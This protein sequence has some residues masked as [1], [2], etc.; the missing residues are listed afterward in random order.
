MIGLHSRG[1]ESV[2]RGEIECVDHQ[3]MRCVSK[4]LTFDD[5]VFRPCAF[6]QD[7]VLDKHAFEWVLSDNFLWWLESS[8]ISGFFFDECVNNAQFEQAAQVDEEI[9]VHLLCVCK[10][11]IGGQCELPDM[12]WVMV[13]LPQSA[14]KVS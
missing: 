13:A 6:G 10:G 9:C 12:R 8:E 2:F 3:V 7:E 5:F 11:I 4:R 14:V 1:P